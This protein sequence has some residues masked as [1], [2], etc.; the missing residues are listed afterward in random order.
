MVKKNLNQ[1]ANYAQVIKD[2][3]ESDF[4]FNKKPINRFQVIKSDDTDTKNKTE[5]LSNLKKLK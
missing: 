3:I 4:V 1:N 2:F 5:K